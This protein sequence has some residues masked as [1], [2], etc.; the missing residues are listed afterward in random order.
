MELTID[1][2]K[3]EQFGFAGGKGGIRNSGSSKNYQQSSSRVEEMS[4]DTQN[5]VAR[6]G[7]PTDIEVYKGTVIG[8]A[9]GHALKSLV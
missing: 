1:Q 4:S 5:K 6:M 7:I 9:G 3:N 2:D 8:K